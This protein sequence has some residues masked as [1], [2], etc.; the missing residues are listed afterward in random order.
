MD[1]RRDPMSRKHR[2]MISERQQEYLQ[3]LT[4]T[5]ACPPSLAQRATIIL[6]AYE[7]FRPTAI[8][9]RLGCPRAEVRICRNQ[10]IRSFDRL[11]EI[12]CLQSESAFHTAVIDAL[13]DHPG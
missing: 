4:R 9:E 5:R 7:R 1:R 11:V 6:F 2:V 3:R 10:W 12:E 8:A 13:S